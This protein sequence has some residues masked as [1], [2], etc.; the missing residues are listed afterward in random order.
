MAKVRELKDVNDK[1]VGTWKFYCP[2]CK[3]N[4]VYD[5]RWKFN[6]NVEKPTFTPSLRVMIGD[7]KETLCH[8][9]V[10]DGKIIYCND[11]PHEF[12]GKTIEMEDIE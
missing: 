4:H 10:T 12:A 9:F 1:S 6:G 8:L 5:K 2:A 7:T 11:C 3:Q